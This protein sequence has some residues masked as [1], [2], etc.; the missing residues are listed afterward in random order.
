M[1]GAVVPRRVNL[2]GN[3]A[4]SASLIF[5]PLWAVKLNASTEQLGFIVAAYNGSVLVASYAFGRAADVHGSRRI[6]QAG[7][8]LGA[9]AAF[10]QVLAT[11]PLTV[12]LSRAFLGF[13]VGMY[14]PALLA[15]ARSADKVMGTFA[16]WGSL[17][18]AAGTLLAGLSDRIAPGNIQPIFVLSSLLFLLGFAAS[19]GAPV[20]GGGKLNVPLFPVEL[21][22]RNLPIYMTMLIRHTGAN[23]VWVIFPLYLQ[24]GLHMDGFQI[25]IA[26][27][28][29]PVVQF[30]VMRKLDRFRSTA[31]VGVGLAASGGTFVSFT[32]ARDFPQILLT[33]V[34]LGVSWATLYVGALQFIV[35]RNRETATAGGI[36]SSV[37]SISSIVGPIAGGVLARR[38]NYLIPMYAAAVMCGV[39]LVTYWVQLRLVPVPPRAPAARSGD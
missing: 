35:E 9:L 37:L 16:A 30:L 31:L 8:L 26:Y 3:A 20:E 29:N 11:D 32:L 18:W 13:C 25:G 19:A 34:L 23:M 14:P 24:R 2:L 36:L 22:R 28:L 17:G 27:T 21:I 7:L 15:Y 6:L 1:G 5:L 12:F 4:V 33:Q 10:L 39:S 38:D